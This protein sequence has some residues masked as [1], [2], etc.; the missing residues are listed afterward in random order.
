L[1][2]SCSRFAGS[3]KVKGKTFF[4]YVTRF[5]AMI[6]AHVIFV[7]SKVE[8]FVAAVGLA[9]QPFESEF[10]SNPVKTSVKGFK[11]PK[12]DTAMKGMSLGASDEEDRE[13][14][15][16]DISYIGEETLDPGDA[17]NVMSLKKALALASRKFNGEI[18]EVTLE[19]STLGAKSVDRI[20]GDEIETD[21][22][23]SIKFMGVI[24]DG[25]GYDVLAYISEVRNIFL[26]LSVLFFVSFSFLHFKQ[27]N[28]TVRGSMH[29]LAAVAKHRRHTTQFSSR[30]VF[31]F[32]LRSNTF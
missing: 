27:R 31:L 29:Y 4:V 20:T 24:Q 17:L 10:V 21:H 7:K 9:F 30:S 5:N 23:M 8:R 28:T 32:C 18:Q 16:F 2:L 14:S 22:I 25:E 12:L 1:L 3:A 11:L 19:L 13:S 26:F 6:H 15:C